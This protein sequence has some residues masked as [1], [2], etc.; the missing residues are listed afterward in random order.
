VVR[1]AQRYLGASL[2]SEG[3]LKR[4]CSKRVGDHGRA[5]AGSQLQVQIYVSRRRSELDPAVLDALNTQGVEFDRVEWIAPLEEQ[6]FSEPMDAAFLQA[7]GG[8]RFTP[9]LRRFWP[10]GGPR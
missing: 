6:R 3:S 7:L 2:T 1:R 9:D 5:Y 4:K 8:A 10:T